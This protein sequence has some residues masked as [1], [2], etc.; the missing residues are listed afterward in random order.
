LNR[1]IIEFGDKWHEAVEI[2]LRQNQ[3]LTLTLQTAAGNLL[4]TM[5]IICSIVDLMSLNGLHIEYIFSSRDT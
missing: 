3:I 2:L 4:G 1:L 5:S